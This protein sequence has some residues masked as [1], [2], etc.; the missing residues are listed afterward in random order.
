MSHFSKVHK[1]VKRVHMGET[2][3]NST[4]AMEGQIAKWSKSPL[5]S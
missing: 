5:R 4:T 2:Q 3:P 1:R